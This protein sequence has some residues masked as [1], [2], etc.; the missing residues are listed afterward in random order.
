MNYVLAKKEQYYK[1]KQA[2]A[3]QAMLE[4]QAQQQYINEQHNAINCENFKDKI[5]DVNI[6]E[7][8]IKEWMLENKLRRIRNDFE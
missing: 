5:L 2:E 6:S 1:E 4:M 8:D 7:K 3:E